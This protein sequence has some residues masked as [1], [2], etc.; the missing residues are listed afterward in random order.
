MKQIIKQGKAEGIFWIRPE[1]RGNFQ[2]SP[3]IKSAVE[4]VIEKGRRQVVIDLQGI[5]GMDSTFMGMLA[6]LALRLQ[7][8]GKKL[9]LAGVSEKNRDSL[10]D[11]GIDDLMDIDPPSAAWR[12]KAGEIREDLKPVGSADRPDMTEHVLRCHRNLSD[13]NKENEIKFR[14]VLQMLEQG[15]R[16]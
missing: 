2:C 16:A 1:G 8:D 3:E 6:G 14:T 10:E 4:E 12:G 9:N 7:D 5:K 13:L 11:L 15:Q